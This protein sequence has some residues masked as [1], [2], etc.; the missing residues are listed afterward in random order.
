[1]SI[2]LIWSRIKAYSGETFYTKTG[3]PYTYHVK[4]RLVVLENT[5]QN[6]PV[7]EFEKA[8]SVDNPSVAEFNRLNLRGPSYIYGIITDPRITK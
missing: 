7:G 8:L 1:M 4:D 5:N 6:I 3:I 2:D